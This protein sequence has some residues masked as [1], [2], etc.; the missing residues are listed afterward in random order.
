[1]NST[2]AAVAVVV[3]MHL[4]YGQSHPSINPLS[5]L[6]IAGAAFFVTAHSMVHNDIVDNQIDKINSPHRAIPSGKVSLRQAKRWAIVLAFLAIGSATCIDIIVGIFP[7][8][9]FWAILNMAI[10][11][12]YN[13]KL[14]KSGLFGNLII[15]YVVSALFLY[16]DIV[17]NNR[18]TLRTESIGLYAFFL[19]WGREVYKD[20][21]DIEGD[22]T[23]GIQTIP[24]RF[25]AKMGAII[26]SAIIMIGVLFSLT[27]IIRPI[28]GIL[29]PIIISVLDLLII[30]FCITVIR[31][32][33]KQLIFRT[34][35]WLLRVLLIALVILA[36]DQL[37]N[38]YL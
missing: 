34:K 6:F 2:T 19:I 29:V 24:V 16:A 14:K 38:I 30:Y 8:S 36:V 23:H 31:N 37:V 33:D 20:I 3:A 10:L 35:L 17:V 26:G 15:G 11:D 12:L 25:G 7:F 21:I 22:R 18:L 28:D 9:I 1:L 27:L 13:L 32:Q 4:A 5:F